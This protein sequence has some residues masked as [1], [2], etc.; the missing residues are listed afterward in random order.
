MECPRSGDPSTLS[1][2]LRGW[3]VPRRRGHP[4]PV[5]RYG[6]Q[7]RQGGP[8]YVSWFACFRSVCSPGGIGLV[9]MRT[10]PSGAWARLKAFVNG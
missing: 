7:A 4:S 10:G 9:T 6:Y 8:R 1:G 3:S 5:G 2:A